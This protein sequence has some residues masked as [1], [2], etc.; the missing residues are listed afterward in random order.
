MRVN[1]LD[2]SAGAPSPLPTVA[3]IALS[4]FP[5]PP[6][7][8][9]PPAGVSSGLGEAT[10]SLP[11]V[12]M[13]IMRDFGTRRIPRAP[14]PLPSRAAG[15]TR[16][17]RRPPPIRWPGRARISNRRKAWTSNGVPGSSLYAF[18][19]TGIHLTQTSA[20][21]EKNPKDRDPAFDPDQ[22]PA[23]DEN[24][25]TERRGIRGVRLGPIPAPAAAQTGLVGHPAC[26]MVGPSGR[27]RPRSR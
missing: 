21:L 13:R 24:L 18:T 11:Q 26:S 23:R 17:M 16:G 8:D 14:I 4:V 12:A 27:L 5:P 10:F 7:T 15:K 9:R 22:R 25:R 2:K 6:K 3:G 20:N 1:P 19:G